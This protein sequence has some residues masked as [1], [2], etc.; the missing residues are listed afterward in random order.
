M[1]TLKG[2]RVCGQRTLSLLRQGGQ[3]AGEEGGGNSLLDL[4]EIGRDCVLLKVSG[5]KGPQLCED[6]RLESWLSS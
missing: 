3:R 5:K 1:L 6:R 4:F 2:G